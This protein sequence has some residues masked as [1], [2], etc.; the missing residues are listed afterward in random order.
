ME[1][2]IAI[3]KEEILELNKQIALDMNKRMQEGQSMI[4]NVLKACISVPDVNQMGPA[5]AIMLE[6]LSYM[7]SIEQVH[8]YISWLKEEGRNNIAN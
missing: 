5:A 7:T 6:R 8:E 1:D 4:G 3:Q 2:T